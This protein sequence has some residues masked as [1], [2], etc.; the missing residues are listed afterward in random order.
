MEVDVVLAVD[1]P[2]EV[3]REARA[4]VDEPA[5]EVQL[6]AAPVVGGQ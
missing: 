2:E 5:G 1:L 3:G 4:A 6:G